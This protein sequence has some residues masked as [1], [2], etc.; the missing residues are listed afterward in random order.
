[1]DPSW[2]LG[3]S[4]LGFH[5]ADK[6]ISVPLKSSSK[7]DPT[8]IISLKDLVRSATPPCHLT[9]LIPGGHLQTIWSVGANTDVPIYYRR[10]V[11]S[12]I[13]PRVKGTF[14]V[15][16]V[17]EREDQMVDGDG[18][19]AH[20][21]ENPRGMKTNNPGTHGSG[22]LPPRTVPFTR[23]AWDEFDKGSDDDTPM[24]IA[25]HGLSGGSYELYLREGIWPLIGGAK[26]GQ[27][28]WKVAVVNSRGCAGSNITS[29]FMF[30]ARSTWD[31]H[32]TV[33]W[34][35]EKFPNRPLFG[36]GFSL[37][38]NILTNVRA[39]ER[40]LSRADLHCPLVRWRAGRGLSAHSRGGHLRSIRPQ[41][42][43]K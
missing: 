35:R 3:F 43:I 6:P 34:C 21:K 23:E 9:P 38:A 13:H 32:Q 20:I 15:D 14:T 7:A 37:G 26:P 8:N 2:L 27:Q 18:D 19:A 1:M 4:K 22:Y 5:A 25:L 16:F 40:R 12:S 31:V 42:R 41:R 24:L 33:L 28:K 10:R 30:N 29:G 36:V 39:F 17:C 11:F